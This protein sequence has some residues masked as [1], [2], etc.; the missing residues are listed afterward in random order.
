MAELLVPADAEVAVIAELSDVLTTRGYP[1]VTLGQSTIATK[2]PTR[3]PKPARFVRVVGA[4]GAN[5]D[6]VT[7]T[8]TIAVEGYDED[9]QGARDLTALCVAVLEA[10]ARTGTLGGLPCYSAAGGVPANLPHPDVPTHYRFTSTL[11][12]ALRRSSL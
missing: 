8:H 1:G 4:G 11:T 7:D 6:L 3:S 12:V 2:I 10:A 9:E 5:R